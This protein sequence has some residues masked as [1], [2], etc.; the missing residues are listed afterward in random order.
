MEVKSGYIVQGCFGNYFT[1]YYKDYCCELCGYHWLEATIESYDD[2]FN[3]SMRIIRDNYDYNDGKL[4]E[5]DVS[6]ILKYVEK[7]LE[8]YKSYFVSN[9]ALC[10]DD[11]DISDQQFIEEVKKYLIKEGE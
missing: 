10:I 4:M 11:Y 5:F 9:M 8:Y 1:D 3:Y 2:I 6:K 7:Y